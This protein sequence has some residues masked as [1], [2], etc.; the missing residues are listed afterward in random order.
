[1]STVERAELGT[2]TNRPTTRSSVYA[3]NFGGDDDVDVDED[4][5]EKLIDNSKMSEYHFT[6]AQIV[7]EMTSSISG[8]RPLMSPDGPILQLVAVVLPSLESDS[9]VPT[10]NISNPTS[11]KP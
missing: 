8:Q 7:A 2:V 6:L 9:Q 5:D 1:M 11:S 3:L 4:E 10:N